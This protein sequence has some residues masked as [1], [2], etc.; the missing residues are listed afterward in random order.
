MVLNRSCGTKS[1]GI[2]SNDSGFSFSDY[3][4]HKQLPTHQWQGAGWQN[5]TLNYHTSKNLWTVPIALTFYHSAEFLPA[6]VG[7]A[8][9]NLPWF[10]SKDSLGYCTSLGRLSGYSTW[11][12]ICWALAS[13]TIVEFWFWQ[14]S[15]VGFGQWHFLQLLH[16]KVCF[17]SCRS[18]HLRQSLHAKRVGVSLVGLVCLNACKR[19]LP[20]ERGLIWINFPV[21]AVPFERIDGPELSNVIGLL[22]QSEARES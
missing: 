17:I 14:K 13:K 19:Q 3:C 18:W 5:V 8:F 22:L 12:I 20:D 7:V 2:L 9:T 21:F 15:M 11:S 16:F 4:S 6:V 10:F 1:R